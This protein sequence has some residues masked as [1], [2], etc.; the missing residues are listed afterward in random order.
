VFEKLSNFREKLIRYMYGRYGADQL[1]YALF[2]VYFVLLL[3]NA[4]LRSPIVNILM[5]AV[6]AW[7]I[8]R[9]LSRNI[10]GRQKENAVFLKLWIPAKSECLLL[11]RRCREIK[12]H[13]FRKCP[14][15]KA[16][17][18]LKRK[19]GK[20]MVKCPRCQNKFQVRIF[21]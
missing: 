4:F 8:C 5:W 1:Y 6:L 19:K 20:L 7:M 16:V 15:C 14:D 2:A 21:F 18:R 11:F 12:T 10:S 17:L 3:L 9:M 13:R